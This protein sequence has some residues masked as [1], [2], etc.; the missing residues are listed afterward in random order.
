[1][2]N[3]S[4]PS[5]GHYNALLGESYRGLEFRVC[6]DCGCR[7]DV[8]GKPLEPLEPDPEEPWYPTAGSTFNVF[9]PDTTPLGW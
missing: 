1:M 8:E 3:P 4:C 9:Y 2:D 5:C 7:T 6:R